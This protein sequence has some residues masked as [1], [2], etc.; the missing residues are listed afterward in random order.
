MKIAALIVLGS[1]SM[2]LGQPASST[3]DPPAVLQG[4]VDFQFERVGL[5][6]P[7]YTIEVRE[8][9]T[10]RYQADEAST[11]PSGSS[12]AVQY[13][14]HIDRPITLS[15]ATVTKIFKLARSLDRFDIACDSKAKNIA[16]TGKKTLTYAGPDGRG[17]CVYNYSE[18]KSVS[19]LTDMFFAI[20]FTLDE[21]R[22]MEFLHRYDRL[23]LDAE[24]SSLAQ[25]EKEG[26]ALELGTIAPTLSAI[27]NDTALIQRVRLQAA[28][29]LEQSKDEK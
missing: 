24:I 12:A 25:E 27:E 21:G 2:A 7:R 29:L 8:D 13:G 10:G 1:A 4:Q 28:R 9:G 14:K 18:N 16:N 3:T 19:A 5:P 11:A 20:A 26:R 6:V 15:P 17:S 23:G 22:R